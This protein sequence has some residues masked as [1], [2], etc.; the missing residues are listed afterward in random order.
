MEPGPALE[1]IPVML[2]QALELLACRRGGVYVDGTVG[3]GGYSEAI[4]RASAPDGI[5]L[6]VDWDAEAIGR[7]AGRLSAYG[8]RAI[9]TKAGFAELPEVLPRHGFAQVD[10]IVL[11]LGVSAFQIDDAARGF[12]FT[13]DGP[14]DMRMDPGLPQT[15][16]DMVN[17]LPEKDLADLIFRLGEERWSRRIARAVVERRRERPFQRTLELADTVAATVP[18]TRDSRRIHPATRT[19]LALRLAVNQELESLE[20]FLSGALDLLKT[21]GRLCVVS[22]HSLEDRMVKGQFKEWAKSCRCPR[23]AVLCR[24]EG[25]PLVRL[26]TRK[27]VR[28]D[29]REKERNPRSRSARLRAVEKQGV[30]A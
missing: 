11:D 5:L 3:G 10:G 27:A 12:S 9:L 7:A 16:A 13:K 20:R 4:L 18:A 2:E 19:F 21:G 1:H 28:P 17:T 26:L 25:R 8:R 30:P 29:E 24:C 23:E 22:F 15:A 14:L 6:G